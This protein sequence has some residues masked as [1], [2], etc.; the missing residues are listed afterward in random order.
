MKISCCN[1]SLGSDGHIEHMYCIMLNLISVLP[2]FHVTYGVNNK[3]IMSIFFYFL[4][5]AFLSNV[6]E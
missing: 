1:I 2:Q 3:L 4:D 6:G 5:R